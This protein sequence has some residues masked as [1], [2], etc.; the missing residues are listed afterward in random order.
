MRQNL[1]SLQ[2]T[3]SKKQD[4]LGMVVNI[5]QAK[6]QAQAQAAA[7]EKGNKS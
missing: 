4:N 3:I 5:I 2:E 6:L 7:K 1:E